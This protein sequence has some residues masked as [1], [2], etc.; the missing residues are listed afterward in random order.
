[1]PGERQPLLSIYYRR[2]IPG[3]DV[4]DEK[5]LREHVSR[6]SRLD[7]FSAR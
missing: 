6:F 1:V 5:N 4:N 7:I 2:V 3:A